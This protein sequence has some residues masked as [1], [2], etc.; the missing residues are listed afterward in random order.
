MLARF[1]R[2]YQTCF[3]ETISLEVF[4]EVVSYKLKF[5][6]K[7]WVAEWIEKI[8]PK[9]KQFKFFIILYRHSPLSNASQS[10]STI[11][12]GKDCYPGGS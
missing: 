4:F 11:F 7:L 8:L 6:Q 12:S 1:H 2:F 5:E 9:H 10:Y 3:V